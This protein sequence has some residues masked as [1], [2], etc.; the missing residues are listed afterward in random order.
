MDPKPFEVEDAEASIEVL[1]HTFQYLSM[2]DLMRAATISK[3]WNFVASFKGLW[4]TIILDELTITDW[5]HFRDALRRHGTLSLVVNLTSRRQQV[6]IWR[7]L[8]ETVYNSPSLKAVLVHGCTPEALAPLAIAGIHLWLLDATQLKDGTVDLE[9]FSMMPQLVELQ[10]YGVGDSLKLKNVKSL[11]Y[12]KTL[13]FLSLSRVNTLAGVEKCLPTSL[14][15]L[16]LSS[17]NTLSLEMSTRTLPTLVNLRRLRLEHGDGCRR[18]TKALF[19]AVAALPYL[20]ELELSNFLVP[21]G[22][23]VMLGQCS[24]IGSLLLL[25]H[26]SAVGTAMMNQMVVSGVTKLKN[27]LKFLMWALPVDKEYPNF[28]QYL[29]KFVPFFNTKTMAVVLMSPENFNIMLTDN[30]PNTKIELLNVAC[31]D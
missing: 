21:C 25:T 3:M 11:R 28:N 22:F 15:G 5:Y 14:F 8:C 20:Y 1:L 9:P 19:Q 6:R 12:F 10:L 18:R 13:R 4:R 27:T 26:V 30:L 31:P 24:N 23:D 2:R 16:D 7:P 17:W 29:L